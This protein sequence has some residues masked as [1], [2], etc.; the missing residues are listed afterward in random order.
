MTAAL[1]PQPQRKLHPIVP[2]KQPWYHVGM[3]LVV[4]LPSNSLGYK[5]I[6]VVVCY[7]S[8]FVTARPLFTK[9]TKS[10]LDALSEIYLTYGVP[11]IIQHDQGKEFTSKVRKLLE[12]SILISSILTNNNLNIRYFH[13]RSSSSITMRLI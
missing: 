13:F 12:T 10:V 5:H 6:L 1:P 3:D 4:D 11:K 9:T 8:K 2:P 7:L